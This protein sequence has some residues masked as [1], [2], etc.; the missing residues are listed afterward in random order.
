MCI[1]PRYIPIR[2]RFVRRYMYYH[3]SW[4]DCNNCPDCFRK[5]RNHYMIR[6]HFETLATFQRGGYVFLDTLTYRDSHI[7]HVFKWSK[8]HP[9]VM[10]NL[11]PT[12]QTRY[13]SELKC[14]EYEYRVNLFNYDHIKKFWKNLRKTIERKCN[15]SSDD[16]KGNVRYF[17]VPEF[18][19]V[20]GRPHWHLAVYCSVPN[21]PNYL[22]KQCI[23]YAWRGI[24]VGSDFYSL[25]WSSMS[26]SHKD[27][28]NFAE[29]SDDDLGATDLYDRVDYN[30]ITDIKACKHIRYV[31]KYVL[32]DSV[33]D[34]QLLRLYDCKFRSQLPPELNQKVRCSIGFGCF[35]RCSDSSEFPKNLRLSTYYDEDREKI[36]LPYDSS[37][38]QQHS[39][40]GFDEYPLITYYIR[41]KYYQLVKLS[42]GSYVSQPNA[43][44]VDWK[45]KHQIQNLISLNNQNHLIFA[46]IEQ[47]CPSDYEQIE[48]IMED[49][50]MDELSIFMLYFSNRDLKLKSMLN[51]TWE[52]FLTR[53]SVGNCIEKIKASN[54]VHVPLNLNPIRNDYKP[55][56]RVIELMKTHSRE[57]FNHYRSEYAKKLNN[58]S[59]YRI[60]LQNM[61]R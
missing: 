6:N 21:L 4:C 53:C 49:Y 44:F 14:T 13:N 39:K 18:G 45:L 38:G 48:K 37:E 35:E 9:R 36:L 60:M 46:L 17:A 32:K 7:D 15:I 50:S 41:R 31:T 30:T 28:Y 58:E 23:N 47:N 3:H 59:Q 33:V 8:W 24:P 51:F 57:L 11:L 43:L 19:H 5:R 22:L 20:N 55:L 56:E 26:E 61:R 10:P 16:V 29:N 42:D 1:N 27:W 12:G 40:V 34:E 2:T 52:K 25:D 54:E